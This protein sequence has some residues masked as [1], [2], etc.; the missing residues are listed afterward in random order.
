[1]EGHFQTIMEVWVDNN[2]PSPP[3]IVQPIGANSGEVMHFGSFFFRDEL[4]FLNCDD[5]RVEGMGIPLYFKVT[6][7]TCHLS[8][9][10][11]PNGGLQSG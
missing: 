10:G 3:C 9:G 2:G 7:N 4:G 5:T 8:G 11:R 1:M 6:P